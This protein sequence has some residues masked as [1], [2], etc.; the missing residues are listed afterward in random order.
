LIQ[1]DWYVPNEVLYIKA[2]GKLTDQTLLEGDPTMVR[3][4][5]MT[6]TD[7]IHLLLDFSQLDY[8][9]SIT[10][11]VK[12]RWAKHHKLGKIIVIGSREPLTFTAS[13]V[14]QLFRKDIIFANTHYEAQMH[15]SETVTP[16][17]ALA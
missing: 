5:D 10:T 17:P 4:L 8:L 7:T 6:P 14:G 1:M 3:L 2:V 9:P 11:Q 12:L 13:L 16:E 15:L